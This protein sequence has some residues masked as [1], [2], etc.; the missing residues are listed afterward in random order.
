MSFQSWVDVISD[1]AV[2]VLCVT[3]TLS[4]VYIACK[5]RLK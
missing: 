2:F 1:I 3:A 5:V 4:F